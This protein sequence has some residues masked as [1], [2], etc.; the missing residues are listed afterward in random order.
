MRSELYDR[1]I[2]LRTEHRNLDVSIQEH[3]ASDSSD[4]LQISRLKRRKLQLKDEI[5][6]LEASVLPD[7]IA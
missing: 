1:L 7:I 2:A 6:K 3:E 4:Q 5:T